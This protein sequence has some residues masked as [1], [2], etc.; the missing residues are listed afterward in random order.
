MDYDFTALDPIIPHPVYAWMGW[1]CVLT[2]SKK[3]FEDFKVLIQEP[4]EF[5]KEKLNKRTK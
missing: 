1:V 3:T 2:P 4:Y 5:A